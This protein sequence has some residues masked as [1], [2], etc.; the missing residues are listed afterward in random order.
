MPG[1]GAPAG[2]F[3]QVATSVNNTCG[4][5]SSGLLRCWPNRAYVIKPFQPPGGVTFQ[6]MASAN[7][8]I[9]ALMSNGTIFPM[10]H[11]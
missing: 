4:I 11:R 2:H 8:A 7:T 10:I 5:L 6:T 3:V 9:F 1:F